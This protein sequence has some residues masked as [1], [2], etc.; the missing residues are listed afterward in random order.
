MGLALP[1]ARLRLSGT[2]MS[3]LTIVLSASRVCTAMFKT[4]P[5]PRGRS[6]TCSWNISPDTLEECEVDFDDVYGRIASAVF[7]LGTISGADV[8][9]PVGGGMLQ[10]YLWGDNGT[11]ESFR[12]VED[13]NCW[14]NKR[15]K[16]VNKAVNLH[17]YPL[18]LCHLDL[19]RRNIKIMEDNVIYLLDW[20]HAGFFPQLF[21]TAALSCVNDDPRYRNDLQALKKAKE[22]RDADQECVNLLLKAR[23]ASLRH[24]L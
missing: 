9:G 16:L 24:I 3:T 7:E 1:P 8:P 18:V 14:L 19:C 10:G 12:S 21:E 4:Y 13:M 15:L 6:A 17:P 20:G 2:R 22:L 11:R 23:A 5:I